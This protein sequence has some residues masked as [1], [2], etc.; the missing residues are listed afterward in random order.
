MF[1]SGLT[2]LLPLAVSFAAGPFSTLWGDAIVSPTVQLDQATVYGTTNG[3]VSSYFNIPFA[4][5]PIGDL[6]L[7]LP[8]P[9]ESYNGTIDATQVGTKCIQLMTPLRTD[10]PAELLR[11]IVAALPALSSEDTQPE[12][13]DCLN[14]NVV[15]PAGTA[16]GANLPVLVS[17]FAGGFS[18]GSNT[19][20]H[21][22]AV[23]RKSIDMGQPIIFAAINYRLHALGFL[24][25][26]E[27]QDAGI[28]N[29]GLHDQ[30]E[31]FRWIQKHIATFGGDPNKVTIWGGS[32]GALS[33]G[34]HMVANRG[35]NEGL[36][37]AAAMSCG[38]V[39]PTGDITVQQQSFDAI[40]AY[41]GCVD[42]EDKLECLRRVPAE[43]L[44]A[45]GATI[46][47][48]FGY[49]GVSA[50][51]WYPHADGV[52]FRE[53]VR[54]AIQ[55]GR[56]ADV[57]FIVGMS[58]DEGTLLASG[59]WNISTDD[60]FHNYMRDNFFPGSS[61][62]EV[63][64][65]LSLYPND[66][67]QGSPFGT[68]DENQLAPMYKRVAAF[69]GDFFFE[70]ARRYLLMH[71]SDKQPAWTYMVKRAPFPGIGYPHGNDVRAIGM[72]EDFTE[73]FIQ[74]IATLDPN[75]GSVDG[76]NRTVPWPR[77]D[78]VVR[79]MLLVQDGEERL[80]VG[81]DDAREEAIEFVTALSLK[82]P[83]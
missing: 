17:I 45:A 2:N 73:Y 23:V 5:P 16:P 66:P 58:L 38:S 26:K 46:P 29:L 3:S 79:K 60:E 65:L 31:G 81:R 59:A 32:A 27:V 54:D 77:Y 49:K 37:R 10:M 40:A 19:Q 78:P 7:R 42:A 51:Q 35:D 25:G 12:S 56:I 22:E 72:G 13:E 9:I 6:R 8:K 30:R 64:P 69:Q 53:P 61:D 55:A 67:A 34:S 50:A 74:F 43:D 44:V 75:G 52:F 4:E 20:F 14:L 24:G 28:G 80:A 68:G 48:N 70:S 62:E 33:V 39:L 1:P 21:G 83:L 15:V 76:S 57:P 11:D 71:R 82:Y 47:G 63:A 36:F 41:V 18:W